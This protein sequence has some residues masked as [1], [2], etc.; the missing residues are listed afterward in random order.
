MTKK[1]TSTTFRSNTGMVDILMRR[2]ST[3]A[4]PVLNPDE[5]LVAYEA[6]ALAYYWWYLTPE[7]YKTEVAGSIDYLAEMSLKE[8][9]VDDSRKNFD[10]ILMRT[11][12]HASGQLI[13]GCTENGREIRRI[14][15]GKDI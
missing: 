14:M 2:T 1:S 6:G 7:N 5:S 13:L 11:S 12:C 4:K 3:A 15:Y 9:G 10:N 8:L